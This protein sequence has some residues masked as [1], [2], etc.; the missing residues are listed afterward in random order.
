MKGVDARTQRQRALKPLLTFVRRLVL[1]GTLV[2][3]LVRY[4]DE[5]QMIHTREY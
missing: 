1:D 3:A 4:H 5:L 2:L